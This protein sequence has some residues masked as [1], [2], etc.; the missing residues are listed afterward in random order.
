MMQ[1]KELRDIDSL[2]KSADN[3]GTFDEGAGKKLIKMPMAADLK[4][5]NQTRY[6]FNHGFY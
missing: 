1:M 5:I 4:I 6:F 3:K 2:T